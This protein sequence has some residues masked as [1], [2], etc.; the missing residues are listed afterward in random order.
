ML[1][2]RKIAR[3]Y[4]SSIFDLAVERKLLEEVRSD[5]LH[6]HDV[7]HENRNLVRVLASPVVKSGK[8]REIIDAVFG[9]AIQELTR[10]FLHLVVKS[11]RAVFLMDI[12]L[13]F[14]ENY[15]AYKG[16]KTA[17]VRT[18]VPIGEGTRDILMSKLTTA[19]QSDIE[20][21]E[22]T[23]SK[24]IGGIVVQ[25]D[26]MRFDASI[27]SKLNKLDRQFDINIYKKGF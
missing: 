24:L 11:L 8:K 13:Q 18:V 19:L 10:R 1:G 14:L 3:S 25:V 6:I 21:V 17:R 2:E 5:M 9:T 4:A 12:T 7:L 27:R 22:I 15:K 23:D 26:D 16:I 20:L